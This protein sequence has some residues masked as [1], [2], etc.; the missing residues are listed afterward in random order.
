MTTIS[1]DEWIKALEDA[2][3]TITDDPDAITVAEFAAMFGLPHA[4]AARKLKA[5]EAAGKA[6]RTTKRAPA[7]DGRMMTCNGYRLLK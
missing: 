7:S 3:L 5:L 2:N 6:Q 1:R 4:T